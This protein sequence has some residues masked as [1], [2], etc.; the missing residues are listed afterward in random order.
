MIAPLLS[1]R[2]KVDLARFRAFLCYVIAA[3]LEGKSNIFSLL[4][5][6]RS[7][8]MQNCFIVSALQRGCRE[9]PLLYLT[10]MHTTLTE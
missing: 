10:T 8:F 6:I 2:R 9:N 5:E 7:I 3:M 1:Q 4:W